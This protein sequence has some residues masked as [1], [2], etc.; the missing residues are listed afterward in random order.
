M[1]TVTETQNKRERSWL[2]ITAWVILGCP[3]GRGLLAFSSARSTAEAED[4]ADQLIT[5]L[6]EA[7][8]ARTP[9][10]DQIVRVLGDDGGATCA[11]PNDALSRTI[12]LSQLTNGAAGPGIRPVIADS[13]VV[14]GPAADHQDLLPRRAGRLP[15][16]RRR[17]QDRRRG[18]RLS[19]G[20]A[21]PHLRAHAPGPRR[22]D[23]ARRA[24]DRWRTHDSSL[25][26][27]ASEPPTG[28]ARSSESSGSP[29]PTSRRPRTAAWRSSGP[30]PARTRT[31]RPS[32]C[33]PTTTSSRPS[34][35]TPG[36][37]RRSS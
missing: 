5:A 10:K 1:S 15:G 35:R 36:R 11:D 25:P 27:S 30:G 13:R 9:D 20:P 2:Y 28:C 16:V 26:R 4:K 6:E 7:A 14:Q 17:P 18:E 32:C 34:T 8:G 12:L 31:H 24:S 37:R 3:G 19:H 23:R 22:A 33:T 21:H 29:T